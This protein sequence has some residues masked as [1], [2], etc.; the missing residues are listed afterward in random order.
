[1]YSECFACK[2]VCVLHACSAFGDQKRVLGSLELEFRWLW[3]AMWVLGINP[4]SLQEWQ[5]LLTT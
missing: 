1:M 2:Y 5:V 3:A 4:G